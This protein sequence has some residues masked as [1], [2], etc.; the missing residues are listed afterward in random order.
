MAPGDKIVF[1]NGY[2]F[3]ETFHGPYELTACVDCG[4]YPIATQGRLDDGPW[5]PAG[6][7]ARCTGCARRHHGLD[8]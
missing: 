4:K 8:G 1:E 6:W 7:G 2:W 3:Y 5:P